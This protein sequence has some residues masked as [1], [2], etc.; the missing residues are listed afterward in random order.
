M[1]A[2]STDAA[3]DAKRFRVHRARPRGFTQAYTREGPGGRPLLLLHGWPETRRIWWRN[4]EPL[5]RAGFEVIAPDLRGFGDSEVAKDGYGDVASHSRDLYALVRGELS[6][7]RVIVAAGDLGGAVAQDLSLRFP[8]F[9]ERLVVFNSPLPYLKGEMDGLRTRPPAEAAD[10]FVRQGTDADGLAAELDTEA[11]RRR[12]IATFYTSRFWAHPGAF[13]PAAVDFM[14]EP[15]ADGA[16]LRAGFAAYESVF[17]PEARSEPPLFG[18]NPTPAVILFGASDHVIPP[19]FDAMAAR[20]FPDHVGPLRV[21]GAGHFLQWEAAGALD[22]AIGM[23]CRP[24]PPLSGAGCRAFVGL[25]SNLGAREVALAGAV[26]ALRATRGVRD[27][28]ASP[29]YETD[30]VGPG[31]QGTYLNAVAR[32]ETT[33]TPHAL[34]ARLLEIERGFGRERGAQRNL[35]RSLDLDLLLFG[36]RVVETPDLVVPHPRLAERAFVLEPL[37]ELAPELVHPT[38]R[39][40]ISRL[41]RRV[42]DPVAVRRRDA[43]GGQPWPSPQ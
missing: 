31:E 12:Y 2:A 9:V 15:F 24:E 14:T 11:K 22:G 39:E 35:P 40:T 34:L 8:G 21:P 13:A 32:L 29:V 23:L 43:R 7:P 37:C 42:R 33:L 4:I 19:D 26:A 36:E 30:P 17:R 10:Y 28:V 18:R 6:H 41:A 38:R 1:S 27:V 5:A 20:V 25:G 16:R 3:L